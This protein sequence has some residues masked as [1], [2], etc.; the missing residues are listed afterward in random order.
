MLRPLVESTVNL[1]NGI[2]RRWVGFLP[3]GALALVDWAGARVPSPIV[4]VVVAFGGVWAV[5]MTYHD[6][7]FKLAEALSTNEALRREV[8]AVRDPLARVRRLNALIAEGEGIL[9]G[10]PKDWVEAPLETWRGTERYVADALAAIDAEFPARWLRLRDFL[11]K[12]MP[13][14]E[15]Q[16]VSIV[17]YGET[18]L[19]PHFNDQDVGAFQ[20]SVRRTV[21]TLRGIVDDLPS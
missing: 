17:Y 5:L 1:L 14:F 13:R 2:F 18:S 21:A 9:A 8:A 11:Q 12:T 7:W 15:A 6:L 20:E 16:G 10:I 3:G 4:W 19:D